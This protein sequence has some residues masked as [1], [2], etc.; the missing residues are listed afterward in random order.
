MICDKATVAAV[1][2][3]RQTAHARVRGFVRARQN[4]TANTYVIEIPL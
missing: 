4:K 2:A 1:V 3:G